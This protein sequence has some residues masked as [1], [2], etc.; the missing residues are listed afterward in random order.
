VQPA[1][2]PRRAFSDDEQKRANSKVY[3]AKKLEKEGKARLANKLYQ[4]VIDKYPDTAAAEEAQK[5]VG[6]AM[7]MRVERAAKLLALGQGFERTHSNDDALG[8]YKEIVA[9]YPETDQAKTA[10]QRI[11]VLSNKR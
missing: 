1:L 6:Y 10:R 8:Q 11:I 7:D 2:K 3:Q 4:E 9:L 5:C